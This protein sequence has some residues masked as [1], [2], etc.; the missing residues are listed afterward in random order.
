MKPST[1]S[2][3]TL[4]GEDVEVQLRVAALPAQQRLVEE[5]HPVLVAGGQ[6]DDV[7]LLAG[8]VREDDP[9]AVEALDVGF[10]DEVAVGEVVQHLVVHDRVAGEQASWSGVGSPSRVRSPTR[11]STS[12]VG[13]ARGLM[14]AGAVQPPTSR[15]RSAL[16]RC[17][18][19]RSGS[20]AAPT[21]TPRRRCRRRRR[22]CRHRSCPRR[23]R[24]PACPAAPAVVEGRP[25]AGSRR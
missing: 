2:E 1:Y 10:G 16:R 22:R 25:S 17:A 3:S 18:S 12:W 11:A 19:V 4:A 9:V 13:V 15:R 24:A 7:D 14:P 5:R 21:G 6:Q 20:R 8:A 23:R